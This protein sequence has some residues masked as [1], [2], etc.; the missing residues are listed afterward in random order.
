MKIGWMVALVTGFALAPAAQGSDVDQIN[1]SYTDGEYR[2]TV[3][4][5]LNASP[6]VVF[7]IL[8][9]YDSWPH[10]SSLIVESQ[11]EE[12]TGPANHR[13]R[14][15]SRGCVLAFCK[16]IDQVQHVSTSGGWHIEAEVLPY[17]GDLRSGWARTELIPEGGATRFRYEMSL[18]P[19]FWIPPIIGPAII[20]HKLREEA[21]ETARIVEALAHRTR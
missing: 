20:R 5:L 12:S 9:D 10:L 3:D 1:V 11:V 19:D 15:R 18:V 4:T 6:D 13:V 21:I 2:V 14:T 17:Q 7:D 16:T 8:T